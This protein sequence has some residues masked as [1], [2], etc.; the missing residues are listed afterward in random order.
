V[1]ELPDNPYLAADAPER[2]DA[3][4]SLIWSLTRLAMVTQHHAPESTFQYVNTVLMHTPMYTGGDRLSALY[5]AHFEL[6]AYM[7]AL[8]GVDAPVEVPVEPARCTSPE[9]VVNHESEAVIMEAAVRG[10]AQAIA[11]VCKAT[12]CGAKDLD[13][14]GGIQVTSEGALAYLFMGLLQRLHRYLEQQIP[15]GGDPYLN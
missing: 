14:I 12:V 1:P 13:P 11:N 2:R 10:D 6:A 5:A 9:C 3:F 15:Q 7:Q 4:R 8:L